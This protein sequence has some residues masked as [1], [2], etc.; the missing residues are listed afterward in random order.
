[1]VKNIVIRMLDGIRAEKAKPSLKD[2]VSQQMQKKHEKDERARI[3]IKEQVLEIYEDR[4]GQQ[5]AEENDPNFTKIIVHIERVLK[6]TTAQT[7]AIDSLE[8]KI[9][10]LS[11]RKIQTAN[12]EMIVPEQDEKVKNLIKHGITHAYVGST[13]AIEERKQNENDPS[14]QKKERDERMKEMFPNIVEDNFNSSDDDEEAKRNAKMERLGMIANNL[15]INKDD[16]GD[17]SIKKNDEDAH[18][19]ISED[20]DAT[21]EKEKEK[22]VDEKQDI[23]VGERGDILSKYKIPVQQNIDPALALPEDSD[24]S[25]FSSDENEKPNPNDKSSKKMSENNDAQSKN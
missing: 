1:M 21:Q 18:K 23:S 10:A 15:V 7:L 11:K 19:L 8:R 16:V 13:I 4:N 3:R 9:A 2:L 25:H 6:I 12:R 17:E 5:Y 22:K 14:M 24:S 20:N